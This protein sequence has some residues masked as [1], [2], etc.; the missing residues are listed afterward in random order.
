MR[1]DAEHLPGWLVRKRR[2]RMGDG[3]PLIF[4]TL[5]PQ[6]GRGERPAT[7]R[8]EGDEPRPGRGAAREDGDDV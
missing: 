4:F 5:E 7:E 1:G 3:R 6:P 8:R 2:I